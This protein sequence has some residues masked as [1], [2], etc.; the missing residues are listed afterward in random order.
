[1][2][3]DIAIEQAGK[4]I[5][6][7][8]PETQVHV[9]VY[10]NVSNCAAIHE[11]LISQNPIY[12]YAFLDAATI[13]YKKQ[14]YSAIIRALEDRRDEQMKTK[15]IHSEVILSLSPKT[16]ISSAFR[17]FSMTKK[18]KNIVVVKIDSQLTEEE[19]FERLDKLVEGN[20]VEFS[21]EELQ[22]LV[23][24]KVL[25]KNYKLDPSTLENPLASILSSIAL[26]GYS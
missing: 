21:D 11:Q 24:F 26:R 1:M 23:D 2:Q 10:E 13:L 12:D 5:L 15:T 4:M 22:K 7:L 8:F 18:S 9:F 14:V 25:K 20:R 6:P 19:E 3:F 17:Q 16:E